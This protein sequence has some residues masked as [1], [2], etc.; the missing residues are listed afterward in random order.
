MKKRSM[1]RMAAVVLAAVVGI[2][3]L[4]MGDV[5]VS[6]AEKSGHREM[7]LAREAES[8]GLSYEELKDG[9]IEDDTFTGNDTNTANNKVIVPEKGHSLTASVNRQNRE[10]RSQSE[11]PVYESGI[12]VQSDKIYY[13]QYD[14]RQ[15][16]VLRLQDSKLKYYV[17][18]KFQSNFSG[19]LSEDERDGL[20]FS[21]ADFYVKNGIVDTSFQG[22]VTAYNTDDRTGNGAHFYVVNGLISCS[23][24]ES[25]PDD[26]SNSMCSEATGLSIKN[27]AD[28]VS[29]GYNRNTYGNDRGFYIYRL[30]HE[31]GEFVF[32]S[33]MD[34]NSTG[35]VDK[36]VER[37]HTYTY[38]IWTYSFY[39]MFN[40]G[41][42]ICG[43]VD[44][45]IVFGGNDAGKINTFESFSLPD[46]S[47]TKDPMWQLSDEG[48]LTIFGNGPM[49]DYDNNAPWSY[50]K[51]EIKSVVVTDGITSIG[52]EA[53]FECKNL[54]SAELASSVE[55]IRSAAFY[56]CT[57]L[58]TV[59][60]GEGLRLINDY[61]FEGTTSLTTIR[62]PA[63]LGR[64]GTLAF[65]NSGLERYEA[66]EG[67][68]YMVQDGVLFNA[69]GTILLS[70]PCRLEHEVY[71]VPSKVAVIDNSAFQ[72]AV[73]KSVDIPDSVKNI[74]NS[75]F[76]YSELETLD[77]PDSVTEVGKYVLYNCKSLRQLRLGR[78]LKSLPYQFAEECTSLETV[79]F[80]EGLEEISMRAFG[81]CSSLK[82]VAVPSSVEIIEGEAFGACKLLENV[83]FSEGL[84]KIQERAFFGTSLSSVDLPASLIYLGSGAFP[85]ACSVNF[86]E[87]SKL[88]DLGGHYQRVYKAQIEAEYNYDMA[89]Q[90]LEQVN[91][92]R[93]ENGLGALKMDGELLDAA[94]LRAAEISIYFSHQ[95][96]LGQDCFTV[97]KK[98]MAENIAAGNNT[99]A[100]VMDSWMNSVVH[101]A[102]IL[103]E[104][105]KGIGI[106]CVLVNGTYYWVQLFSGTEADPET[107]RNDKQNFS[108]VTSVMFDKDGAAGGGFSVS[109]AENKIE[110]E[111]KTNILVRFYNGYRYTLLY[112]ESVSYSSSDQSVVTVSPKG[113]VTGVAEGTAEVTA[114]LTN[115]PEICGTVTIIVGNPSQA[116][117]PEVTPDSGN[118]SDDRG[119]G[120]NH[121]SGIA[122]GGVIGGGVTGGGVIGG[123]TFTGNDANTAAKTITVKVSQSFKNAVTK[124]ILK[125]AK[126]AQ[127][128][129][130]GAKAKGK[131]SYKVTRKDARKVLT[132]S[133]TGKVTIRKN[134]RAGTY[135][136]KVRVTAAAKGI[137]RKTSKTYTIKV[138]VKNRM[139]P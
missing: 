101:K 115:E 139:N 66:A 132:V 39:D 69:A 105:N 89:F 3:C 91:Q 127:S 5:M 28:G 77:I 1:K 14:E 45:S 114:Y 48:V 120:E 119:N 8:S 79:K 54:E 46:D 60:L 130:I 126:K 38:Y 81:R 61:A 42:Y 58:R 75:A 138:I 71:R 33:K 26:P 31:T 84:K 63:S 56:H 20:D 87:N 73:V 27:T 2:T 43:F 41:G 47:E 98:V 106:G 21:N 12:L 30:C 29:V 6:A 108:Q 103:G 78:G 7:E 32:F 93:E 22:V 118:G 128:F 123:G 64:I 90:V 55:D 49:P 97:N 18:G 86:S 37:D 134:A 50:R 67:S 19:R 85:A 59:E 25:D 109:V 52:K 35:F 80:A 23:T 124:K 131:V 4:P 96:P 53:F 11:I 112:P 102:N 9:A 121:G 136:V 137:Y 111:D 129:R 13:G 113:E 74:K 107:D 70:Y 40:G 122:G 51:D 44:L 133:K 110:K 15:E 34:G 125:R 100:S 83:I 88:I 99:A 94:M 57:S 68:A 65:C 72:Y 16:G 24:F 104:V 117:G 76:S 36:D 17:D 92:R 135:T 95:R 62:L 10:T 82:S 116:A